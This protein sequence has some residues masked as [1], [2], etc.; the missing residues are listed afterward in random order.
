MT[1]NVNT[2][3]FS[4]LLRLKEL[5]IAHRDLDVAIASL[6]RDASVDQ[7]RVR[8]LKKE[9]LRLKD[10]IARLESAMIPDLN[11]LACGT[12]GEL[13]RPVTTGKCLFSMRQVRCN[14]L[15][16][17]TPGDRRV[18]SLYIRASATVPRTRRRQWPRNCPRPNPRAA[19]RNS[20]GSAAS[21]KSPGVPLPAGTV[22]AL[23]SREA[24]LNGYLRDQSSP[25]PKP[26]NPKPIFR[27]Q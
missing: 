9:K 12:V 4:R 18:A 17:A 11:A 5:R 24:P 14:V 6:V 27:T 25:S 21:V 23:I 19:S 1:D 13:Y 15:P 10:S 8:R 22:A 7:L 3:V 2:D 16:V 20:G 26:Q